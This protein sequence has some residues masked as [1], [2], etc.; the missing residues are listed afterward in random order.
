MK[1]SRRSLLGGAVGT[2]GLL[3][4][5]FGWKEPEEWERDEEAPIT[6]TE[7][8]DRWRD[9]QNVTARVMEKEIQDAR[10]EFVADAIERKDGRYFMPVHPDVAARIRSWDEEVD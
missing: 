9:L 7:V 1:V 5:G 2:I 3:F 4:G 10:D 6:A 8:V